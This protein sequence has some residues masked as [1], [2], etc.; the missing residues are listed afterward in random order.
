VGQPELVRAA[1]HQRDEGA[2]GPPDALR[3]RGRRVVGARQ[4]QPAQEVGH[5]HVLAAAQADDRL[6][7]ERVVGHGGEDVGELLALERD[8][9]GHELGRRG[10]GPLA[11]GLALEDHVAGGRFD[12]DRG[13]GADRRRRGGGDGRAREREGDE[14]A[15]RGQ[16]A[17]PPRAPVTARA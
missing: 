16:A 15:Q 3:Q 6:D 14:E 10:D 1:V 11:A 7:R 17:R 9:R 5:R 8:E 2:V 13:G 4:Q 12:Q